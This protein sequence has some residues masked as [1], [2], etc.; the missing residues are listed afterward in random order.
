MTSFSY[1]AAHTNY[2]RRHTGGGV[3]LL[4]SFASILLSSTANVSLLTLSVIVLRAAQCLSMLSCQFESKTL[5][6][7]AIVIRSCVNLTIV[8]SR[9]VMMMRINYLTIRRKYLK[10]LHRR[11]R[12]INYWTKFIHKQSNSL[13]ITTRHY[14]YNLYF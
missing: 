6:V 2:F 12:Q 7:L 13:I 1:M 11:I 14:H 10:M 5:F 8:E 9:H 3:I 4:S